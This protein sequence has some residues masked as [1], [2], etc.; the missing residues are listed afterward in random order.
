MLNNFKKFDYYIEKEIFN[1]ILNDPPNNAMNSQFFRELKYINENIIEQKKIIGIIIYGKGRH[2]S[3]GADIDELLSDIKGE[4]E[5]EQNEIKKY[6]DFLFENN[7][8]FLFFKKLDI[9]I[10]AAIQGVC[11]GSALEFA[12]FCDYRICTNNALF[13]LP[14][15]TYN[16]FPGCGGITNLYN[17]VGFHKALDIILTGKSLN[18]QE[19]LELKIIHKIVDKKNLIKTATEKIFE[20]ND[21]IYK[22]YDS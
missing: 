15:S 13:G 1:L 16:L 9:P 14:E 19:A 6:P 12:L 5:F 7:R 17:I 2:F 22:L 8:T 18:A 10:I 11:I 4:T 21:K 3:A 20:I